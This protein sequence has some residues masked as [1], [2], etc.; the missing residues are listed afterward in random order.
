MINRRCIRWIRPYFVAQQR[1]R[2]F[3]L[4]TSTPAWRNLEIDVRRTLRIDIANYGL[5]DQ[6]LH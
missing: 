1:W 3:W 6:T 2:H 5:V 4:E